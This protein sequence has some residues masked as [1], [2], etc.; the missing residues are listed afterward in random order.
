MKDMVS[1][2]RTS[3]ERP[4]WI[5]ETLWLDM[6]EQWETDEAQQMSPIYSNAGFIQE[7]TTRVEK[8]HRVVD[9]ISLG[10]GWKNFVE[11]ENLEIGDTIT[12]GSGEDYVLILLEVE[13]NQQVW[14]DHDT[15]AE[16]KYQQVWED[17]DT[18]AEAKNQQVWEDHDTQADQENLGIWIAK[19]RSLEIL[20]QYLSDHRWG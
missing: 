20:E 4:K 16:A 3:R 18:Q 7:V 2:A 17:H 10:S 1:N 15:Q 12:F 11:A 6:V 9:R 8:R 14:E 13:K 19:S 5:G